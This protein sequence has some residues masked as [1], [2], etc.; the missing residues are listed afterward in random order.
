M[1]GELR[2]KGTCCGGQNLIAE[3][4]FKQAL[5]KVNEGSGLW[6]KGHKEAEN[7]SMRLMVGV[8]E[9]AHDN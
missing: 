7:V 4:G 8:H 2:G 6:H 9:A 1:G 5:R 3:G